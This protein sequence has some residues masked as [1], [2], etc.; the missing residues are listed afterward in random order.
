MFWSVIWVWSGL[1]PQRLTNTK[2]IRQ[3]QKRRPSFKPV[4][5]FWQV[6]GR[7]EIADFDEVVKLDV[8][9]DDWTIW[10]D[11]QIFAC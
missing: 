3:A 10:R 6:S 2:N 7:S 8:A 11:I 4:L 1:V 5:P 9:R